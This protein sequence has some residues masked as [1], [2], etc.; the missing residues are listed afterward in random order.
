MR[1]LTD[2]DQ[3]RWDAF[4]LASEHAAC[5]HQAGWKKVIEQSFG[6]QTTYLL[7]ENKSGDINGILPLVQIKSR[8]F[9]NY[10]VSLPFFNYGG[11]CAS[12]QEILNK[13]VEEAKLLAIE[14]NAEHIELRHTKNLYANL[15]AKTTKVAMRLTLPSDPETLLRSFPA[16]LRSQIK[17]PQ[18]EGMVT[19]VGRENELESFY[20]VF[21]QNMRDLGTPVY[22]MHFFKNILDT[23]PDTTAICTVYT[24]GGIPVASGFLVG[25]KEILEIPWASSLRRYN[26]QSPNMLLY[27][28]VLKYG[29]EKGYTC[30][31]FGRSTPGEGTY[32]FKAQWGALPVQLYWHYWLRSD[33]SLPESKPENPKYQ[34]AIRIWKKLPVPVTRILGPAIAK[35]LPW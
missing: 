3:Q 23:F 32:R 31:D 12:D 22:P 13:L 28:S 20:A 26:S 24:A 35:N 15:P 10:L 19:K 14:M 18:K 30:F 2:G 34:M 27:W 11:A 8:I 6:H 33:R 4:V 1:R 5:Y 17:R 7:S 25:F 9:G 29:C 16:K 21:S